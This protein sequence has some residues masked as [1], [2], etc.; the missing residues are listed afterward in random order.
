MTAQRVILYRGYDPV[1]L[2]MV[3]AQLRA[4]EIPFVRLG[5]GNALL[6]DLVAYAE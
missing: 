1:A 4:A 3:E 2:D 6:H 5:Q